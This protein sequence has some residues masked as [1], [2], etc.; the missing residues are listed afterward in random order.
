MWAGRS[1]SLLLSFSELCVR[2]PTMVSSQRLS[3]GPVRGFQTSRTM[4]ARLRDEQA[5][6]QHHTR[7]LTL[8]NIHDNPGAR[9]KRRRVGRGPGSSKGKTCGRGQKG[10][11][12]RRALHKRQYEGG[13]STLT[14][15]TPK[16]GMLNK[17]HQH[18]LQGVN[19]FKLAMFIRNGRIDPA[20]PITIKVIKD[21]GVLGNGVV[22]W[23][24]KLLANGKER[25]ED[26]GPLHFEVTHA[27][28]D[29]KDVVQKAGGSVKFVY[30]NPLGLRAHLKPHKFHPAL[31]PRHPGLPK[32]TKAH[33]FDNQDVDK[34]AN[35]SERQVEKFHLKQSQK[36]KKHARIAKDAEIRAI[37]D[38]DLEADVVRDAER[39]RARQEKKEVHR[40]YAAQKRKERRLADRAEEK[41]GKEE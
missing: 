18:P 31:L 41:A 2:P 21:S 13:Q 27:S 30:F 26:L 36:A 32:P 25:M 15:R 40:A 12:A 34:Y 8:H 39:N 4:F 1:K 37:L 24:V 9:K 38:A 5:P 35:P 10:L 7:I 17:Y 14:R 28:E 3:A 23:G 29:A 19:L 16:K 33:R 20:K 6:A 11:Y 22:K